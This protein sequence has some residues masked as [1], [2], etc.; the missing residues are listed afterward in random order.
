MISYGVENQVITLPAPGEILLGV[1]DDLICADRSNHV[2]V[3]CTAYAS[4]IC[5]E[6]PGDLHSERTH[7]SR[8]AVHQ[9]LLPAPDLSLVAKTLQCGECRD[10]YGSCLLE[11]H[12]IRFHDYC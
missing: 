12:V 4:H 3:P 10:R 8:R 1:V 11:R 5:A 9:D 6:R 2:H 7:A